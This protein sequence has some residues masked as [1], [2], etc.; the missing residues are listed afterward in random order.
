VGDL[1]DEF[2]KELRRRQA[3]A[4]GRTAKDGDSDDPHDAGDAD[5]GDADDRPTGED[6]DD[7][8]DSS[9]ARPRLRP[10]P[11]ASDE[12]P[13]LADDDGEGREE[14]PAGPPPGRRG[15][16]GS[17]GGRRRSSG[18][19]RDGAPSMRSRIGTAL[20]IVVIAFVVVMLAFGIQLWTDAI[21][22]KS[23]GYDQVFWTRIGVQLGLFLLGL[24]LAL[25]VL[26]G[27]LW[28]AG[29]LVPPATG[30]GGTIRGWIDRLNEAAANADRGR[31]R[32]PWDPWGGRGQSRGTVS[33]NPVEM[34]DLVPLGRIAIIVV[35]VLTALGVAGTIS[36]TWPTILLWQHRVPFD[37]S[38]AVV[39]DPIFGRDISFYLFDL[40]FLRFLQAEASGLLIAALIVVGARYLLSALGG[41]PVFSTRVRVHLGVLAALFL[42]VV[43][44]GYQLDKL[45]LVHSTRGI[46]T[47]VSYTDQHAQF[48]AYDLLTAVSAITAALLLGGV[49]ARV[50][51]P[52]GI[53][54]AFWFIASI[55]IGRVYPEI[56]QRITVVPN[57]QTLESPYITNNIQMTRLA[58]DLGTWAEQPYAGDQPLTAAAVAEDQDTFDNARLWDYRPLGDALNQLQTIRQ[59]Y[60]FPDVDIDRYQIGNELRQVMLAGREI[61]LDK[62]PNAT[63]WVNQRLVYTHGIG[64]AM[65]QVSKVT[66]QGQP[67]L[68]ISNLPPV[69]INGAPPITQPRIYFGERPSGYV[70]VGAQQ[71]EFDYPRGSSDSDVVTNRWSGTTGIPLDT[72]LSRL[73]FALRFR[74]FDMLISNQIT[75][76]SQLLMNR[77]ISERVRDIAPF[78]RYD[79]DP[80]LVIDGSGRLKYIQDGYTMSDQF[81]NAQAFDPSDLG[82][83]TALGDQPFDYLRNSVK[84]VMDAYDGTTTFYVS[85]PSDPLIRAWS[86]V[87]PTLFRP[88]S[89]LPADLVPHLRVPEELFDVQTRMFGR[90]H[91][92]DPTTFYTNNDLWTIPTGSTNEQSLP[93]EAYY[94]L[95]RMPGTNKAEFLLLQ[96]MIPNSRPNMIAWVAV[97]NDPAGYGQ[98][99]VFRF[100]SQTNVFGPAQVEA[101]I[102]ID[103]EISAQITLWNQSGSSVIRGNLIVLPVGDSLIYL[104]PVYLQSS[105]S[106]FPAFERIVVASS[107]HVV[108]AA[109]LQEAL[110]KFLT[111]ESGSPGP[112]PSPTPQPSPGPSGSPGPSPSGTPGPVPSG[113]VDALIRFANDHF[114]RAQAALRAGDFATY[115]AEIELV[116]QALTQLQQLS[117]GA[118]PSGAPST[119]SSPPAPSPSP[120][121]AP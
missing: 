85:D 120:S 113:D 119:P 89:E 20:L 4:A 67:D 26:L 14:P 29:R 64:A 93:T 62:N 19:P 105:S 45:D 80:Y 76:Q 32:G 43:A 7:D 118:V 83:N 54:I 34:P 8:G 73:L 111:E 48:L 82:P 107:N 90:Y 114:E 52:V 115:G 78:L 23:V 58:F 109:T 15:G 9:T 51:W 53:T 55:A 21:W 86:G 18:G 41:S 75:N 24:V 31:Q 33:V 87:F 84:V 117:G 108:W 99:S 40:P 46:A 92:V 88:L 59:Y 25:A 104:Q 47:G 103:P 44:L 94:V 95:M 50:L 112:S 106:K 69:S 63:G 96:P 11:S 101:Q 121:P 102:D 100:P 36:G 91:V 61:A 2:M 42:M 35:I 70:I 57:Q 28:L 3:E 30:Q 110:A 17:G 56:V 10:V 16:S 97:R 22:F 77:T 6:A 116:R 39:G 98:T 12:E 27:N 72:T 60:A 66:P 71:D 1:F 68:D 49:F 65:V 81:P 74:D 79:K 37:P 5:D 13:E 38:G